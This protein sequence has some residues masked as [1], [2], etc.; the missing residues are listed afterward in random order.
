MNFLNLDQQKKYLPNFT[1]IKVHGAKIIY[2]EHGNHE[3]EYKY[4]KCP[5]N[6]FYN[7]E[8]EFKT[9]LGGTSFTTIKKAKQFIKSVNKN[10]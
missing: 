9:Y 5:S 7:K 1:G 2:S 3:I 10:Q 8:D 6:Y 4:F